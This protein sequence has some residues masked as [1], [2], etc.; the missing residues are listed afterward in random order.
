M[1]N[2]MENIPFT[3]EQIAAQSMSNLNSY[4]LLTMAYLKEKGESVENWL[5]FLGNK[6]IQTWPELKEVGLQEIARGIVLNNLSGGAKLVS[7]SGD[8]SQVEIVLEGWP[9]YP[10]LALSGVSWQ[11]SQ[12]LHE[13]LTPVFEQIGVNYAWNI[14]GKQ[15]KIKLSR[16]H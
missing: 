1:T 10:Y 2:D 9:Q 13:V 15:V 8:D 3:A 7:F 12:I 16:P 11:E 14:E 4:I 5:H 6:F